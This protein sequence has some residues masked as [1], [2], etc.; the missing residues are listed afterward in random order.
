MIL[1]SLNINVFV[2]YPFNPLNRFNYFSRTRARISRFEFVFR[3]FIASDYIV[4]IYKD[5]SDNRY[6]LSLVN[7]LVYSKNSDSRLSIS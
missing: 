7:L 5:A 4:F 6:A 2:G 1:L 3:S